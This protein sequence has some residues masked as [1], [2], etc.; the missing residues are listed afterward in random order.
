MRAGLLL[1]GVVSVASLAAAPFSARDDA[2][3]PGRVHFVRL[4]DGA[5]QPQVAIDSRNVVHVVY[6]K[7]ESLHGELFHATLDRTGALSRPVP[8]NSRPGSAVAT[9][10]M[11]GAHIAIGRNDR[12]HVAWLGSDRA[13]AGAGDDITPVLYTRMSAD[14][15]RFEPERNVRQFTA[16][17]D[18]GSIAADRSGQVYVT[19]HGG[20]AGMAGEADRN[21]WIAQ[22]HDD[23]QSFGR[24]APAAASSTGACGCCG[25][26]AL[27]DRAGSLFVLYR[28]AAQKVHR[29]AHLLFSRDHAATFSNVDPSG[30][31]H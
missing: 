27:A 14:G 30:M 7:G 17:L 16:F 9:G 1:G 26:G 25:L 4:P 24:E 18:G 28:S 3:G 15:Q 20:Q 6:F 19:W 10:T 5:V 31:E 12:V 21:V 13:K 2:A 23:G 29:D 11:R 22:S 8:V